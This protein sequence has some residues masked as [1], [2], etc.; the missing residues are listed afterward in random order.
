METLKHAGRVIEKGL[1]A[2]A[3][4]A[5]IAGTVITVFS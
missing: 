1:Y 5:L 3:C 2:I 4:C